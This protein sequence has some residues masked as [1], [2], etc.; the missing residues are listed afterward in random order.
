MP[1]Q[2]IL[3]PFLLPLIKKIGIDPI[4]FGVIIVLNLMIGI[5]TPPFGTG[6]FMISKIG[7]ISVERAARALLPFIVALIIALLI[8]TYVPKISLFLPY[9]IFYK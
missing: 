2:I 3:V 6:L 7:N 9:L 8:V 5:L 1:A 4:H